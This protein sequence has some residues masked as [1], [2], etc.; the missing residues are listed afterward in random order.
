MSNCAIKELPLVI[1]PAPRGRRGDYV[2]R[3]SVFHSFL[4]AC[5][6]GMLRTIEVFPFPDVLREG[7]CAEIAARSQQQENPKGS[8][9][10]ASA[11]NGQIL[12]LPQLHSRRAGY[13]LAKGL[14]KSAKHSCT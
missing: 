12:G 7:L 6:H 5:G 2:S 1:K 4:G 11:L 10:S 13:L 14:R 9:H 3:R 8:S